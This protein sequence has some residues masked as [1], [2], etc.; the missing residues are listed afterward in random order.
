MILESTSL[1][2]RLTG[3]VAGVEG[4]MGLDAQRAGWCAFL[5]AISHLVHSM[6]GMEKRTTHTLGWREGKARD[7][8]NGSV[9]R[10][11]T[12]PTQILSLQHNPKI[13][14]YHYACCCD[15]GSPLKHLCD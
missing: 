13:L 8:H 6:H 12:V 1:A 4:T 15:C 10:L 7:A 3:N 5:L 9:R 14:K 2:V 11:M